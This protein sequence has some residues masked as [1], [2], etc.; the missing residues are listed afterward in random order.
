VDKKA[1]DAV[2]RIRL[3][4][5]PTL[6]LNDERVHPET[7]K[8]LAL[9]AYLAVEPGSQRRDKLATLF[10]GDKDERRAAANLRRAFWNLRRVLNPGGEGDCP[11]LIVNRREAAFNRESSYWLDV[12]Q[13]EKLASQEAGELTGR[14]RERPTN[15]P[16]LREAVQLY[17]GDFLAGLQ[18]DGAPAFERWVLGQRA[19]LKDQALRAFHQLS[20]LHA[21]RG[22]HD[23]ATEVLRQFLTL[24]P[25]REETHRQ[26][27]L[28]LALQ[29]EKEQA[30]HQYES[31]VQ[32]LDR[33]MDA[34]P[35]QET[36]RLYRRIRDGEIEATPASPSP[37]Q[38]PR[39][40][41]VGRGDA[42]AWLLEQR[43]KPGLTLVE[44]EAGV[45]KT[46][47]LHEVLRRA[48]GEG[49]SVLRGRCHEFQDAVPYHAVNEAIE[50]YLESTPTEALDLPT[51]TLAELGRLVPAI[52]RLH[53]DVKPAR[54]QDTTAARERFFDS[55]AVFLRSL[56][57]PVLFLDDL[58]WANA[59]TV[60]LL[61]YL[62]RAL[63]ECSCWLVGTYRPEETSLEHPLTRMR[64]GLN[65]DGLVHRLR[66]APLTAEDV[67]Q[68][69]AQSLR[70]EGKSALSTYLFRQSGG[71][72]FILTEVLEVL[73]EKGVLDVQDGA[74]QLVG[75]LDRDDLLPA[76][77]QDVIL[78]RVGRLSSE[79]RWPLDVA[80]V[81]GRPF[82]PAFLARAAGVSSE[83]LEEHTETWRSRRLIACDAA[84]RCDFTHDKIRESVYHHLPEQMRRLLHGRVGQVLVE[85]DVEGGGTLDPAPPPDVPD[86]TAARV[87][88]HFERS[89]DTDRAAPYL[90]QAA[91][92]ALDVY[93]HESAIDYYQRALPLLARAEERASVMV[94]LAHAQ[95]LTGR[96]SEA[97]ALY[98][99]AIGLAK[100]TGAHQAQARAWYLLADAQESQ[101]DYY[102]ALKSAKKAEQAARAAGPADREPLA[103]A[104]Y[105]KGWAVFRLGD[106]EQAIR[107]GEDVLALSREIK[108][109]KRQADSLNLLSAIHNQS[110][111][112][113][114]AAE[115]MEQAL[116]LYREVGH[117]RGEAVMLGNLGN[118]SYLRGDYHAAIERYR[119][120][121]ELAR[122]I[123]HRYTEMLC[124]N[125]LGGAQVA[126]EAYEAAEKNLLQVLEVP[127]S[128]Q[129]FL[130]PDTYRYLA[131]ARLALRESDGA[132]EAA[133]RVLTLVEKKE[134]SAP[135][136]EGTA[137]R[138]LGEIAARKDK[139]VTIRGESHNAAACFDESLR[140]FDAAGMD[141][142]HARTL[143]AQEGYEQNTGSER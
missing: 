94:D 128:E 131:E 58:H 71:N 46:R 12:E 117:R 122:E 21:A 91:R 26:V 24:A 139:P 18:V 140:I 143:Q 106:A 70:G 61:H 137:W 55:V 92:S 42:Y 5:A 31:C 82:T 23:Q 34:A 110:G 112:Y 52:S 78:Q 53:P 114:Q 123:G 96:W 60:D 67:T 74:W 6:R 1:K 141:K 105:R 97:E 103:A 126:V 27:M 111:D 113:D 115:C 36:Q 102:A 98:Q 138:V 136:Y 28:M 13:F 4:G 116:A 10:W 124:L 73:E 35:S 135:E 65:R 121:L 88:Y 134:E 38:A 86:K 93:A 45:G 81:I 90:V 22:E 75:E 80:A 107:L 95:Q 76:R 72:P 33:E 37:D 56:H 125:N 100:D 43:T 130:L 79:A 85:G 57:H 48:T 127:G 118:T 133:R 29:G 40:P 129:W 8:T 54:P 39:L 14:S 104:L 17:R 25:W 41:F 101:G 108:A 62:T 66:L 64:Q 2:L 51:S 77:V 89:L 20:D 44:G 84:G 132:L 30:L 120:G 68:A 142:E 83:A 49:A 7:T 63:E 47:L 15:L 59:G 119:Q 3:L 9:L 32:T 69:I 19:Y 109:W 16:T 50:G 11:Y 99:Q 87:A